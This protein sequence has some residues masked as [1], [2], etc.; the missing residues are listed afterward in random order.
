MGNDTDL[1]PVTDDELLA[2]FVLF[3]N[4]IRHDRTVRPD[5]FIPYPYPDLSVTRH[6]R[7]SES[8]LW[9]LGQ[10]VSDKIGRPLYGRADINAFAV[11]MQSL[12][13][14]PTPEP[15]NH[16]NI[17]GWPAD[18]PGQKIIAQEITATARFVPKAY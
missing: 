7:V 5:A 17:T 1:Q 2:R 11:K 14:E 10:N 15:K 6:T 13:I 16:A 4:W 18:K 9:Q 12:R 3:S 8:E